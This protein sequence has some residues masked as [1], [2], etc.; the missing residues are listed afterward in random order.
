MY[1]CM[2]ATIVQ[3]TTGKNICDMF[4]VTIK[5]Q[6]NLSIE[7]RCSSDKQFKRKVNIGP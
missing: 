5:H 7:E 3:N 6:Y 1:V 4:K 2:G